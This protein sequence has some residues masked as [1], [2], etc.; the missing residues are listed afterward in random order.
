MPSGTFMMADR[1]CWTN[2]G[3]MGICGP[4]RA[5]YPHAKL[6]DLSNL[7]TWVLGVSGTCNY[8]EQDG[9]NVCSIISNSNSITQ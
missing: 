6:P 4:V 3:K 1:T 7:E 5:C 9:R 8:V 2:D